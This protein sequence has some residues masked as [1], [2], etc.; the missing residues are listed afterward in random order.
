M[1]AALNKV[2]E[3]IANLDRKV[4]RVV[5][6]GS[7][8]QANGNPPAPSQAL[9][10]G[11]T[12]NWGAIFKAA[13]LEQ[14]YGYFANQARTM[15]RP[16]LE[17]WARIIFIGSWGPLNSKGNP[18]AIVIN[19][20]KSDDQ[21]RDFICK[22][23]FRAF[24]P[25]GYFVFPPPPLNQVLNAKQSVQVYDWVMHTGLGNPPTRRRG[26]PVTIAVPGR[27]GSRDR[28]SVV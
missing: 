24:G 20:G 1:S 5:A 2:A 19:E 22:S 7:A 15:G 16:Q 27:P 28:K 8:S 12:Y 18:T 26:S 17:S 4:S 13:N 9:K 6:S 3:Q 14:G 10:D 21:I 25:D 23:I 11:D